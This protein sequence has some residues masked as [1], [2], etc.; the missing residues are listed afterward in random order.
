MSR[1]LL[2]PHTFIW[3]TENHPRLVDALRDL[4]DEADLGA[5]S[6]CQR[7]CPM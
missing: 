6:G 4:I 3:L 5:M 7:L 2:D 1:F